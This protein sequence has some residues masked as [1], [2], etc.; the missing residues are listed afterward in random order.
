MTPRDITLICLVLCL[1]MKIQAQEEDSPIPIISAVPSSVIPL[2]ESVKILCQGTPQSFLYQLEILGN[3]T[4]KMVEEKYGFQKEAEF[5]INHMDTKTA[6]RYQCRYRKA[7]RWSKYSE[8]LQLV[9]TGL[10]DKP[11][12]STDQDSKVIPGENISLQCGSPH[13]PF[14]RFSLTTE[15]GATL[16]QHQDEGHQGN[17]TLGPVTPGF[18]GNYRCYGWYSDN[19]YVW[20][21]P[22][23]TLKLVVKGTPSK[24]VIWAKPDVMIPKGMPVVIWCQGTHKT[25]EYQLHFEGQLSASERPKTPGMMNKVKFPIPAMTSSTAGRYRC[26][27][28]S[29]ELWSE[30]SDPLDLVV[31]GMYDIPT[32]S[33]HPRPEVIS[34]ENVTFCCH[35]ETATTTFFLLK[36]GR[37]SRP[38]RRY[39]NVQAK[40]PMGPVT[41][42]HRGT[43]RCFGS[44]NN[45]VWSFPSEPVKLLVTAD[46]GD[47]SL[48]PTEHISS[49]DSWDP[50][51]LTTEMQ[52]QEDPALRNY[53]IQNLLRIGLAFLVL[54]ALVWLLAEDWL[55]RK[56]TQEGTS[57]ASSLECRRR[58]RTQR[59]L[60]K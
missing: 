35:L 59:S 44:Y 4:N 11:F 23:D 51:L 37:S 25:V 13:T 38:W 24:P 57:R 46:V 53:A 36:E 3:S 32:L 42:A 5:I 27:Y 12:L 8:A 43:Y 20:S 48:V 31:T 2:N 58:F 47:P 56:R 30:P 6:G 9:V 55:H 18:S 50:Y 45:H 1:G 22:S 54:V 15:G 28:R 49:P 34:G 17:F 14:D 10:Y 16:P 52:F 26:F 21:A 39:G 29:G 7:Y 60:D 41:T 33:V 19:P 40:F